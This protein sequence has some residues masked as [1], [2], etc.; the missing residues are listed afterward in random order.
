[1]IL[2]SCASSG[3]A[4]SR[5]YRQYPC[6]SQGTWPE[7][8]CCRVPLV[9]RVRQATGHGDDCCRGWLQKWVRYAFVQKVKN[10]RRRTIWNKCSFLNKQKKS[11]T[12]GFPV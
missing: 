1:M 8:L 6:C 10:I 7:N 2:S 9:L 5:S 12:I 11:M 3:L 4:R